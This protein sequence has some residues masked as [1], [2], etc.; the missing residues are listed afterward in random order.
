MLRYGSFLTAV[1]WC[2]ISGV[3]PAVNANEVLPASAAGVSA[4]EGS[5]AAAS[6]PAVAAAMKDA[7]DYKNL[8]VLR[9]VQNVASSHACSLLC[10]DDERCIAAD[11]GSNAR[12]G[13]SRL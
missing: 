9:L 7:S 10:K 4:A 5:A 6:V 3:V 8:V 2:C 13:E 12:G 1:A 11:Y